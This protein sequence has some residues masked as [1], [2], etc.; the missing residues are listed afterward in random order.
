MVKKYSGTVMMTVAKQIYMNPTIKTLSC[1]R[2]Q[3]RPL[4]TLP[5]HHLQK[6]S[7]MKGV[8]RS[9]CFPWAVYVKEKESFVANGIKKKK[10]KI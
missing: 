5:Q 7:S 2:G 8:H 9:L 6:M 4:P 1:V 10:I 3:K